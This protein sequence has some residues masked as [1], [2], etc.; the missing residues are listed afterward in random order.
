VSAFAALQLPIDQ[1]VVTPL[2]LT[3][4]DADLAAVKSDCMSAAA[5]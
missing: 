5:P 4:A 2:R 3:E 1:R